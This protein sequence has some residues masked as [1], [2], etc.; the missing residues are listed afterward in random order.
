M[1]N[2]KNKVAAIASVLPTASLQAMAQEA[3][4]LEK[5]DLKIGFIPITCP[6]R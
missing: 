6:R 4:P 1:K 2:F 5:K 3:A